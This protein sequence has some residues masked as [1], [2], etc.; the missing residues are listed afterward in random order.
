MHTR[1]AGVPAFL[2]LIETNRFKCFQED[3]G[4]QT[5]DHGLPPEGPSS[6]IAHRPWSDS[7]WFFRQASACS[8]EIPPEGTLDA[9]LRW[10]VPASHRTE[11]PL[12]PQPTHDDRLLSA[13]LI[14]H[15][16]T[17]LRAGDLALGLARSAV[18]P[19]SDPLA[20]PVY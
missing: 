3:D 18:I 2:A 7:W 8:Y 17:L 12:G 15:L 5:T 20:H 4:P 14:A 1:P 6:S 9:N 13:A 16:D 10:G 19:A 11:T